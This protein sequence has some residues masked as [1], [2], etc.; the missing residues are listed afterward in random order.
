M[1]RCLNRRRENVQSEIE[2]SQND[3][4]VETGMIVEPEGDTGG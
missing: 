2:Y 4:E 3:R 1:T